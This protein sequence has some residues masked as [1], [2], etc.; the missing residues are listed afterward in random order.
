MARVQLGGMFTA[1]T[2]SIGGFTFQS[3]ASGTIVRFRSGTPKAKTQK[4]TEALAKHIGLLGSWSLLT[5]AQQQVWN[6]YATLFT[7]INRFGQVK[8]LTGANWYESTNSNR[9][10]TGQ[11][12]LPAPPTH[13]LPTGNFNFSYSMDNVTLEMDITTSDDPSLHG[14][15][16]WATAPTRKT[17]PSARGAW[18][19]IL[20]QSNA[21][22]GVID[23]Q[24]VWGNYFN[25][26]YPPCGGLG[27]SNIFLLV[28]RVRL[29]SGI[30]ATGII[31]TPSVSG[32]GI[33]TMIIGSTFIV[34]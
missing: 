7:K 15:L 18:R 10:L 29:S 4:Q 5:L 1:I 22:T 16:I 32:G 3:N 34:D 28:Q 33:G 24:T 12:V 8:K 20:T 11:S 21:N 27:N 30:A 6:D 17:S 31:K 26:S 14:L 2:G 9:A 13:Q 19:L 25:E 23:L